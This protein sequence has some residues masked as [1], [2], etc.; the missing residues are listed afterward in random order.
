MRLRVLVIAALILAHL[1]GAAAAQTGQ[2]QPVEWDKIVEAAKQEGKVVVSIPPIRRLRRAME[3]AFTRRYGIGVEFVS[4]R[5]SASIQKIISETMAGIQYVDL[6][7]GG[8]E[9]AVTWLLAEKALDPV[10][11]YFVLPEV[12]DPKQWWGGH[13][14]ADNAKRFIYAFAAYQTVNLWCNPKEYKPEEFQSFDDLLSPKLQGKIGI[15]DPR[16]PGSGNSMW[17]YMLSVKGEGYLKNL[18]AQRLFVAQ[19]LRLLGENLSSGKIAVTLG[20]GYSDAAAVYQGR[21]AGRSASLSEGGSL[22]HWR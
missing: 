21:L 20:I 18:V 8:T 17:S 22:H 7:V 10:E 6:H 13:I 9:S 3:V 2:G 1:G 4:V 16:M 15:S 14:W 19:D 5:G 12:K 11:P